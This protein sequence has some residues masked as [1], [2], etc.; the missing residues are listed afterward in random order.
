MMF[1]LFALFFFRSQHL[2]LNFLAFEA[3]F[4]Y[5][6]YIKIHAFVPYRKDSIRRPGRQL[7]F[8]VFFNLGAN[9]KRALNSCWVFNDFLTLEANQN[10]VITILYCFSNTKTKMT[11]F[12]KNRNDVCTMLYRC[13]FIFRMKRENSRISVQFLATD[14]D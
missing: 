6:S 7:N 11:Y 1:L 4:S 13:F 14:S 8:W 10:K 9:W 3:L 2:S 12:K 5:G